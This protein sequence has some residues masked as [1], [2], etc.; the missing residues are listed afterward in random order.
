MPIYYY[1]QTTHYSNPIKINNND[2]SLDGFCLHG[3][4]HPQIQKLQTGKNEKV[5]VQVD[6]CASQNKRNAFS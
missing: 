4:A 6:L 2:F 3:Y 5:A 1:K